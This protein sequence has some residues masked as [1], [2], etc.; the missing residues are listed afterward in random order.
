MSSDK[1]ARTRAIRAEMASSGANYSRAA[2]TAGLHRGRNLRAV[3][4]TCHKDIP[5]GGGV[6]HIRHREVYL[7]EKA[8]RDAKE[9]RASR[10]AAEGRTGIAA[11]MLTGEDFLDWPAPVAWQVHC[12][13]C[14]PHKDDDDCEGCYWFGVER[15]STWSQLV[16]WTAHLS[17][18]E[19]VLAATN[20]MEFIRAV[21]HGS[22]KIG[23]I[24][25][26]VDR[27]YDR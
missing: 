21:A 5:P 7:V 25:D 22:S 20:W 6:I 18:K 9:R 14:N 16:E 4:F 27:Y 23:L 3:C 26:P 19:W 24:C 8:Q 11:E 2:R 1:R 17:E 10:A 13:D 12:D 15:C